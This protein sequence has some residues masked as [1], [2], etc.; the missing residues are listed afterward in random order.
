MAGHR[1]ERVGEQIYQEL[2]MLLS[3]EVSDPRLENVTV[4]RVQV[5]GDLR[6]A[7]VFVTRTGDADAQPKETLSALAHAA[8]YLRHRLAESL[9]LRFTPE[10]RFYLDRSIEMGERFLRALEQVQSESTNQERINE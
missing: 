5:S 2:S 1:P 8:G 10:L 3:R 6:L 9:D 7:K 4:T